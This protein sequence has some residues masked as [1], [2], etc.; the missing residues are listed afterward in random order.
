MSSNPHCRSLKGEQLITEI[1]RNLELRKPGPSFLRQVVR[2][3]QVDVIRRERLF[4]CPTR[5][6][7]LDQFFGNVDAPGVKP[8]I[9]E[10]GL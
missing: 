7:D 4:V 1:L 8:L 3:V 9:F 2:H 10:P 5:V 6:D